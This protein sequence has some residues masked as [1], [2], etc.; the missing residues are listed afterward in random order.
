MLAIFEI[1]VYRIISSAYNKIKKLYKKTEYLFKK[2]F[3]L[4]WTLINKNELK[5]EIIGIYNGKTNLL[6]KTVII[7]FL[8]FSLQL[9]VSSFNG[10]KIHFARLIVEVSCNF[11]SLM[12]S[13]S[14]FFK[15]IFNSYK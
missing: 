9:I 13:V 8:V 15:L 12:V 5:R 6:F 14:R 10:F 3:F 11:G 1:P 7:S 2:K 4:E